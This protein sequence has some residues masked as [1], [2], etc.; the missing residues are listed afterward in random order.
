MGSGQR[1][2]AAVERV[3]AQVYALSGGEA[4][5]I[6]KRRELGAG[7]DLPQR[8]V[9]HALQVLIRQGLVRPILFRSLCLTRAGLA[10]A[11]RAGPG[12]ATDRTPLRELARL[13]SLLAARFSEGELRTLCFDLGIDYDDLPGGGKAERARELVGYLERHGR[14]GELVQL[15]RRARPDVPWEA[16]G[17]RDERAPGTH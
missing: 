4:E 8:E 7:L 14:I 6:L 13:R 11:E 3:L 2:D 9:R 16:S 1:V 10:A 15:G 17:E 5:V 12:A